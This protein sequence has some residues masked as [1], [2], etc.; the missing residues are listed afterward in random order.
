[1]PTIWRCLSAD[2]RDQVETSTGNPFAESPSSMHRVVMTCSE[3]TSWFGPVFEATRAR[4]TDVSYIAQHHKFDVRNPGIYPSA[5]ASDMGLFKR[6]P[7]LFPPFPQFAMLFLF[8]LSRKSL[9]LL[10]EPADDDL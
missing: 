2:L 6:L 4:H 8:T 1:M 3:I 9:W 5:A 7:H 10:P